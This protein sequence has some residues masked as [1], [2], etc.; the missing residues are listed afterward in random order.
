MSSN[1]ARNLERR[2]AIQGTRIP[3]CCLVDFMIAGWSADRVA[4]SLDV[5]PAAVHGAMAYVRQ[6]PFEIL[7]EYVMVLEHEA[8]GNVEDQLVRRLREARPNGDESIRLV[9]ADFRKMA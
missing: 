3:V 4:K 9:M 8:D 5:A 6:H 7:R 2:P 1:D